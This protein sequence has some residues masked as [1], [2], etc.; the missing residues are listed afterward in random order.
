MRAPAGIGGAGAQKC[1]QAR[2]AGRLVVQPRRADEFD[3]NS[4]QA[5]RRQIM[6][7]QIGAQHVIGIDARPLGDVA[8]KGASS[9]GAPHRVDVSLRVERERLAVL[10]E[11]DRQLRHPQDRVVDADQPV[12]DTRAVAHRKPS[13]DAQVPVQPRVEPGPAVGFQ[14]DHLPSG[15]LAIGMLLDPKVG[16]VRVAADDPKRST[17]GIVAA[18]PGHQ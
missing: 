4:G 7:H 10:G 9:A 11:M 5:R 17:A 13:A 18:V 16:A 15:D 8:D 14:R 3:V 12:G 2:V 6:G 1:L